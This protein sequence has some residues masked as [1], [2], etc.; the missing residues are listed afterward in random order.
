MAEVLDVERATVVN[1][2][3][4]GRRTGTRVL[5]LARQLAPDLEFGGRHGPGLRAA[6]GALETG[7]MDVA[8]GRV[9]GVGRMP[10]G[11][12]HQLIRFEP[13][14]VLLPEQHP[15]TCHQYVPTAALRGQE[16]DAGITNPK[17][18]EWADLAEQFLDLIDARA[19]PPH[20]RP[21]APRSRRFTLSARACQS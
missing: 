20:V 16:V 15:L 3:S 14:A 5:E 2:H 7:D 10:P 1:L 13:L 4:A 19:I 8:F 12:R 18:P 6:I 21:K 11:L 17:A 9:G